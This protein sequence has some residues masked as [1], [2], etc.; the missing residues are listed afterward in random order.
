MKKKIA[1]LGSTGSIGTQTLQCCKRL[2]YPVTVLAANRNVNLLEQ[3]ARAYHPRYVV[4]SDKNAYSE[5]KRSLAD[6][7]VKLLAGMDGLCEAA[8]LAENDMVCNALV[9]MMGLCPTLAALEAGTAIALANKETLVAAGA[10]VTSLAKERQVEL[11]PVDSEH[12]AI[13]QC[14]RSGMQNEVKKL[15]LTASGGPFLGKET[16]EIEHATIEDTLRHP[17]WSMG[18]KISVDSAT[19]MNKGLELIEAM[20]LFSLPAE[21]IEIV[22]HPQSVI[23]SAVE[24][25]DG[26]VIAQLGI[27]DMQIPIQYALTHPERYPTHGAGLSLTDYGK[28]TF[29]K[30]DIQTF[31]CL[32]YGIKAAQCGGLLPCAV[33][34]AN[35]Q[36]VALFLAGK[37]SLGQ[38][39]RAI[40]HVMG[41][42]QCK[43]NEHY[44]LQDV[45]SVH[46]TA[47]S[48]VLEYCK[49]TLE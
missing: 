3:Q 41:K 29:M 45:L 24:F 48:M 37:I 47:S 4:V 5:I 28:L 49:A 43:A 32:R 1:V 42:I 13:F 34:S 16:A 33:N 11:L 14:L 6:T 26:A 30:P 18:Q 15:L 7:D 35:E 12:S 23:H 21:Q 17:N 36:A 8:A 44:T 10:L 39:G 27:P 38:I 31:A 22:V 40:G 9:G 20:W 46:D 25:C 2:G 19:L